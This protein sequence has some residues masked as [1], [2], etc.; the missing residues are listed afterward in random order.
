MLDALAYNIKRMVSLISIKGL[1]EAIRAV[2]SFGEKVPRE[3][4]L[5]RLRGNGGAQPLGYNPRI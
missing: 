1:I 5:Q 2:I 4:S 3:S